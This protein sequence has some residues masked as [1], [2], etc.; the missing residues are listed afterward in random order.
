MVSNLP[1]LPRNT[2]TL[3]GYLQP[4]SAHGAGITL[5]LKRQTGDIVA[6][7]TIWQKH[8]E[9]ARNAEEDDLKP[10]Y[11]LAE[12]AAIWTLFKLQ[13]VTDLN[14]EKSLGISNWQSYAFFRAA[15]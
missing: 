8:Y 2:Y 11:Y 15:G 1:F 5:Q 12:P 9:P 7:C 14:V 13:E 3:S 10:Y 6:N 4:Q